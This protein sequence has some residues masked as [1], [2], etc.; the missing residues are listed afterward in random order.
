[1]TQVAIGGSRDVGVLVVTDAPEDTAKRAAALLCG[2][3]RKATSAAPEQLGG[4][5]TTVG[6]GFQLFFVDPDTAGS[7]FGRGYAGFIVDRDCVAGIDAG[8]FASPAGLPLLALLDDPGAC[9]SNDAPL[10]FDHIA[11]VL[12]PS[13]TL[14]QVGLAG[15]EVDPRRSGWIFDGLGSTTVMLRSGCAAVEVNAPIGEGIFS[16]MARRFGSCV[17]APVLRVADNGAGAA[18]WDCRKNGNPFALA[19]ARA[20]SATVS[21]GTVVRAVLDERGYLPVYIWHG[22]WPP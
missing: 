1:M 2:T 15:W 4:W 12:A 6:D 13:M 20:G 9:G 10:T 19:G 14:P 8:A 18:Y 21:F 7:R 17:V 22:T 11:V 5:V 3:V 16:R